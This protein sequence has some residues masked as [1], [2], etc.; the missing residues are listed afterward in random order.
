MQTSPSHNESLAI[1]A[2][3]MNDRSGLWLVTDERV[4]IIRGK[5]SLLS[6]RTQPTAQEML[7]IADSGG[8]FWPTKAEYYAVLMEIKKDTMTVSRADV[9]SAI[10]G[11]TKGSRLDN[12][13]D[14]PWVKQALDI[15]TSISMEKQ[16]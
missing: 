16:S 15:L 9:V 8:R 14:K 10:S 7:A 4:A 13:S 3:M 6:P 5:L 12:M 1:V 2:G 11:L